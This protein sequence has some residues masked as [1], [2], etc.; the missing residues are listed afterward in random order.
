MKKSI[1]INLR[2]LLDEL[3][4]S[5]NNLVK[6][7]FDNDSIITI[8]DLEDSP[9]FFIIK[10]L[11]ESTNRVSY[12]VK[13]TPTS[14]FSMKTDNKSVS[15]E[16]LKV[17]LENWFHLL[18]E[19][20]KFSPVF[21]DNFTQKYYDELEPEFIILDEDAG[22]SPF[23]IKQQK[24]V[25]SFL[26]NIVHFVEDADIEQDEKAIIIELIDKTEKDLSKSTK[27]KV[28][29]SIRKVVAMGFKFS[30]KMGEKILIEYGASFTEKIIGFLS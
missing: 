8:N 6:L 7:S 20:N 24:L 4:P 28:I 16:S 27:Q 9:Y 18:E 21:D 29:K 25:S 14:K 13:Y 3:I 30:R 22:H 23:S 15:I 5:K 1:P 19:A 11:E 26:E 10:S 12:T 2:Q 17:I